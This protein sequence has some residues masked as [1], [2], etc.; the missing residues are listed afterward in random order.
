[1]KVL[2][3][4]VK[5]VFGI[6]AFLSAVTFVLI[7][8]VG[9]NI[10]ENYKINKSEKLKFNTIVPVTAEYSGAEK[11]T[12]S[13][14]PNVYKVDL[15]IFGLIPFSSTTVQVVDK[16][17]VAVLG[18]PF[19]MKMYTDG[20]LVVQTEEI[21]AAGGKINV[22]EKAGLKV[23]DY[24][25]TV[26]G[27]QI[28]CNEDLLKMVADGGGKTMNFTVVRNEKTKKI[29]ITP[30]ADSESGE[31]HIGIWV[32]DSSAGIGTLT[33]YSPYNNV[34]CGLGHEICDVD[35]GETLS[36]DSGEM[37]NANIV[38][39]DKASKGEIGELKGSFTYETLSKVLIN[40]SN[41]IYGFL[42]GNIAVSNLTEIA[43]KQDV[44]NGKAQVLTTIRGKTPQLYSCEI[45]LKENAYKKSI[46]NFSVKI[47]D[48]ELLALTGGIVQGMSGSPVLQNGRLIGAI[49][50]VLVD[51]PT[52]GYA[53][54]AENM[55]ETAQ[56]VANENKLK[57]AS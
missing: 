5:T 17:Q 57:D 52:T 39:Y 11:S 33:F 3:I 40:K 12:V 28:T 32:R 35:T 9:Q 21:S 38:A 13:S 23:G 25:R 53:I 18:T 26:N 1:M 55:L 24:I 47:T 29:K 42:S 30:L 45:T 15:K 51:D 16:M 6:F 2:N 4:I 36:L 50:H 44:K 20:V 7:V 56:S 14:N 41:G 31:Y 22:A 34:I 19:G 49:T 10:S 54:F 46:Q 27:K 43:H 48:D 37:V 8:I